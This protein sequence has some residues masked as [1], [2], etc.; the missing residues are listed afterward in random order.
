ML[1]TVREH[2]DRLGFEDPKTAHHV[3]FWGAKQAQRHV[4]DNSCFSQHYIRKFSF[5][6][7]SFNCAEQAMM[8]HKACLFDDMKIAE[9]IMKEYNPVKQKQLG[10]RVLG[11]NARTWDNYKY[12]LVLGINRAKFSQNKDMFK[13]M[14]SFPE[15]SLFVEASPFDG[16]WGVCLPAYAEEIKDANL[17][18]GENL[19]GFALTDVYRELKGLN[20]GQST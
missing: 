12:G 13:Y 5:Q 1:F 17:W 3:Y 9:Q 18:Q 11:F 2:L 6:G 15:N 4:L 16:I 20:D 19:L 8:Y 14:T 10:R 7:N